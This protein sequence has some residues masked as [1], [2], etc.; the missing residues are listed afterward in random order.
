MTYLCNRKSKMVPWMSGL[1]NGLQ[2]R[3]QQFESARHLQK[4]APRNSRCRAL[5]FLPILLQRYAFSL[6]E[7]RLVAI[8]EKASKIFLK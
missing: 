3:L 8:S 4:K 2:N 5:F 1:V 7:K 6:I